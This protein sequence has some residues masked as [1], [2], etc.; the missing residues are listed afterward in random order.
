MP[1]RTSAIWVGPEMEISSRPGPSAVF[2][3]VPWTTKAWRV[4]SRRH[5]FGDERDEVRGVDAHDLRGGSGGIGERAEEV[6]D[7]ADAEG[8]ADGHDGLHGRVQAGRVEEGEAMARGG[9]RWLRRARG[10]R[11]CRGLR[12]RRLS[13]SAR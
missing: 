12:G 8:A 3:A 5:G 10:R 11:G 2:A 13:R 4:P 7:G 6:E 1:L 9:R